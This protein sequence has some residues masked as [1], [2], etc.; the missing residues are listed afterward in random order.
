[1]KARSLVKWLAVG[2][3]L[4]VNLAAFVSAFGTLAWLCAE[5]R[6]QPQAESTDR[7]AFMR[8]SLGLEQ[9]PLKYAV[10]IEKLSG[11][12]FK[13]GFADGP[14]RSWS[15]EFGLLDA[16][17]PSG[18]AGAAAALPV[19]FVVSH[20]VPGSANASPVE[21]VGLSCAA[22]HSTRLRLKDRPDTLPVIPGAGNAAADVIAFTDAFKN[23]VLDPE[24]TAARIIRE[25]DAVLGRPR[26]AWQR[27]AGYLIEWFF[28]AQWLD[29]ARAVFRS[30]NTKYDLPF[31]GRDLIDARKMPA[32]PSRTRPFRS[33]VRVTMDVPGDGNAAFS[34]IPAAF[35]Q[36]PTVRCRSQYDGSISNVDT[37]SVVAAFT[38]GSSIDAL[39]HPNVA[40]NV[41]GAARFTRHLGPGAGIPAFA[42]L[43]PDVVARDDASWLARGET[44][45]AAHCQSCHGKPGANGVLWDVGAA[46]A[47]KAGH[48][49]PLAEIGTDPERILFRHAGQIAAALHVTFP[50]DAGKAAAQHDFIARQAEIALRR[51]REAPPAGVAPEACPLQGADA[52]DAAADPDPALA[53]FWSHRL[54]Q[55]EIERRRFP[56]GHP[57]YIA[58]GVLH[59]NQG[60]LNA[61]IP[62]VYLRAPYLHNGSVPTLQQLLKLQ[63]RPTVFCRGDN[64]F[65]PVA[66]GIEAREV[67][68]TALDAAGSDPRALCPRHTPF[69]FDARRPG[70][71]NVGH[72]FPWP[73]EAVSGNPQREDDVR[74]LIAFL[75]RF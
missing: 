21:F 3:L 74:A 9:F 41:R 25:G 62:G 12:H 52:V 16:G 22:C 49:S 40:H 43:F 19:G 28:I 59:Y 2:A 38:S 50:G 24:L 47:P 55:F 13:R 20:L 45:Y 26:D 70:N 48:I 46:T 15:Q 65:D 30:D 63:P 34:K 44:V 56:L 61:P 66:V 60:Y 64:Y 10:A 6:W 11:A 35:H 67:A 42:E 69:L 75:R 33:V 1:M 58:P 5:T 73:G 37:R 29:Q 23:A 53:A 31:H 68:T 32:G 72:D 71:A 51:A 27:T 4:L 18:D 8:G 57:F 7:D 54:R 39:A 36:D 14:T 17:R